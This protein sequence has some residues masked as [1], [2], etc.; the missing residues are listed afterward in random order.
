MIASNI[1]KITEKLPPH[2]DLVAVSKL[3][4]PESI[5]EAYHSG[6][7]H[8]GENRAQEFAIKYAQLPN[9]IIWHFIGHIQTN[10]VKMIIGKAALIHSI[11]SERLLWAVEQEALHQGIKQN[12]L[13]QLHVAIE[14]NK[15]GFSKEELDEIIAKP[16]FQQLQA[17]NICGIM[18]MASFVADEQQI[19]TEFQKLKQ[20][21]DQLKQSLFAGKPDFRHLSMGMSGDW[22]IAIEEGSNLIR[23]GSQIFGV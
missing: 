16:E 20:C 8:F 9:D 2:V 23:V 1:L 17:V 18:G 14:E 3:Q 4:K 21:Y 11:D 13:L 12:C 22:P 5:L 10:K 6:Q 7:R 15:W 19:R